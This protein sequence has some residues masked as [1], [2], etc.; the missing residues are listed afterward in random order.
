[1]VQH[2]RQDYLSGVTAPGR[3][4]EARNEEDAYFAARSAVMEG[5]LAE[6][7]SGGLRL[8]KAD[9]RFLNDVTAAA[10][11]TTG[12]DMV[13]LAV[14]VLFE[15]VERLHAQALLD[16]YEKSSRDWDVGDIATQSDA[17]AV[18]VV[19]V[20]VNRKAGTAW[21]V[22]AEAFGPPLSRMRPLLAAVLPDDW[23]AKPKPHKPR[24]VPLSSLT[25]WIGRA[26]SVVRREAKARGWRHVIAEEEARGAAQTSPTT[27]ATPNQ[28]ARDNVQATWPEMNSR[29]VRIAGDALVRRDSPTSAIGPSDLGLLVLIRDDAAAFAGRLWAS[30]RGR[31]G[32]SAEG[33]SDSSALTPAQVLGACAGTLRVA[34]GVGWD[35]RRGPVEWRVELRQRM[36]AAGCR[37]Q[38]R[39]GVVARDTG[40]PLTGRVVHMRIAAREPTVAVTDDNGWVSFEVADLERLLS[41]AVSR[42]TE[43]EQ[44][45]EVHIEGLDRHP[46]S[47]EARHRPEGGEVL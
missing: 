25:S 11:R 47:S 34:Q 14:D 12:A 8:Q 7:R 46:P 45:V 5:I 2:L 23:P 4:T 24:K 37:R 6:F 9:I 19:I 10:R 21:V 31:A 20:E 43:N 41:V 18:P 17:D 16:Q 1:M 29:E 38:L 40:G 22:P 32:A 3:L 13:A 33:L 36:S 35:S 27:D 26:A 30:S 42:H 39:I 44:F 15:T 28:Q